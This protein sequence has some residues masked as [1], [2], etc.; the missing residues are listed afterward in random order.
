VFTLFVVS[1]VTALLCV[2]AMLVLA[3]RAGLRLG[4]VPSDGFRRQWMHKG[5]IPRVGGLAVVVACLI[6]W[7]VAWMSPHWGMP[8]N[9]Q[10]SKQSILGW[11][12]ALLPMVLVGLGE[13]ISHRIGAKWRLMAT[14]VGAFAACSLLEVTIHRL[15]LPIDSA[16]AAWPAL[17]FLLAAVAIGGLPHAFNLIDGYNG[18]AAVVAVMVGLALAYVSLMVGD[19]ELAAL[20]ICM[21]GATLGFL[22]WNYPR[23][24]IFAG[25]G[26]A[27]FWGGVIALASVTLV[28]RHPTVSPWFPVLLLIYPV[29]ETAFS[30]YRKLMR[31]QSPGMADCLHLHQLVY[32]RIVRAVV[33]DNETRRVLMRNN[34]TSPY[35]WAFAG[36]TV[37]PAALFWNKTPILI[38]F[39]VLFVVTYVSAYLMIVRF[40]VPRWIRH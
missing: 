14:M 40:K 31:G 25:D 15:G 36:L 18:L 28:Q 6:A 19:R 23:G 17:G 12:V 29:W 33:H 34:R 24:L 35:L 8:I 39:C 37:V 2:L 5:N 22:F 30:I 20:L 32:R 38:M 10:V 11:T 26:G 4:S 16:W 27:Y 1:F 3:E 13:D 21:V 9:V 7:L